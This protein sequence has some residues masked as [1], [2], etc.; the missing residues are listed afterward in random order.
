MRR[1]WFSSLMGIVLVLGLHIKLARAASYRIASPGDEIT[2]TCQSKDDCT[3]SGVVIFANDAEKDL[4]HTTLYTSAAY[5]GLKYI[6]FD[7][8]WTTGQ[9]ST[10][11]VIKPNEDISVAFEAH[12]PTDYPGNTYWASLYIDAKTC[13]VDINPPDCYFYGGKGFQ[14]KFVIASPTPTPTF[15]PTPTP[16]PTITPT[17]I[18]IPTFTPSVYETPTV[19]PTPQP[20]AYITPTRVPTLALSQKITP[21]LTPF[22]TA[23]NNLSSTSNNTESDSIKVKTPTPFQTSQTQLFSESDETNFSP[24][25]TKKVSY[26][27]I[28]N[29]RK[30]TGKSVLKMS[31]VNKAQTKIFNQQEKQKTTRVQADYKD[32]PSRKV[33]KLF[34]PTQVVSFL[35]YVIKS[36]WF[37]IEKLINVVPS[38]F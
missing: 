13:K 19:T 36:F 15:M 18:G 24:M 32:Q 33:F 31:R 25:S 10:D 38:I 29:S 5:E 12:F 37:Q 9:S 26:K 27:Q 8:N 20:T 7:G 14:V 22:L 11:R 28:T 16:I 1:F 3:Y 35:P 17:P 4:Y 2:I 21:T 30:L 23:S 34:A 6:G